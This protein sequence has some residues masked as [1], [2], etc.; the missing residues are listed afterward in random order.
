MSGGNVLSE[1]QVLAEIYVLI[2][3]V[4]R[5]VLVERRELAGFVAER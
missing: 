3:I 5:H 2:P 1:Q 4:E